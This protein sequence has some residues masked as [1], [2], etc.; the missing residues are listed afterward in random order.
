MDTIYTVK[1]I[2]NNADITQPGYK[3]DIEVYLEDRFV[4]AFLGEPRHGEIDQNHFVP[5]PRLLIER[6]VSAPTVF[7]AIAKFKEWQDKGHSAE[8]LMETSE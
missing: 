7:K 2:A 8:W 4:G 1:L 6:Q 5:M 3:H